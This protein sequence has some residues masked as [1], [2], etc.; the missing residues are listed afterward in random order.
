MPLMDSVV[1]QILWLDFVTFIAYK[2]V[3]IKFKRAKYVSNRCKDLFKQKQYL[4]LG[5]L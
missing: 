4:G 1:E 3:N 2:K 5:A